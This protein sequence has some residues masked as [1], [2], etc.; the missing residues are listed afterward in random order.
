MCNNYVKEIILY[1]VSTKTSYEFPT[2]PSDN[3]LIYGNEFRE[4]KTHHT[5]PD[6]R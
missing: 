5:V 1:I 4:A 2:V 3:R 6:G